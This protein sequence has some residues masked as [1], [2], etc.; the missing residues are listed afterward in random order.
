[1]PPAAP[2]HLQWSCPELAINHEPQIQDTDTL[3]PL[4]KSCPAIVLLAAIALGQ[5]LSQTAANWPMIGGTP[6]NTHYST[7]TQIDRSNVASLQQAW[8]FDTGESGG[9]ETTPTVI[10]GVL[11]TFTPTQKVV[12][13]NAATGK[14]LWTFDSGIKGTGPDRGITWWTDGK[15]PRLLAG[16]MNF[17]Y[18]LD[19]ATG[20]PISS[21]GK[22]GRIDLRENLGREPALQSVALTSPG[23]LYKNLLIVGGRNPETLPA[24][25][26]DI[27]AYSVLTGQLRW[28]FHTIPHPGEFG[29]NTWPK[30]AWQKSGAANNWAGMAVDTQRGIVYVP[31]GSAVPDFYG[32]TRLGNDLFANTLLAL[33]ANTGKRLWHFQGVHHDMWD[34]DFPAAPIL[35][36][37]QRGGQSIPAIA[38]TTKQGYLYLFN[39]TTGAPLFPIE[40]RPYPPST[41]PGEQASPTQP[42]P[43]LPEPFARQALTED[44]LTNR[45][46][47]AHAWALQRF[48]EV[49]HDGQFTPLSVGQ[50]TFVYPS[51]EG[52]A[53][54]GG[55]A[56]DPATGILYVNANNYA[57]LGALAVSSGGSPGRV[58]YLNQCSVCHGDHRQGSAEFPTL[59]GIHKKL[60]LDQITATIHQGKGRMPAMPVEG[61]TLQSLLEYLLTDKD[62]SLAASEEQSPKS[63]AAASAPQPEVA[64]YQNNCAIC[65]G[66]HLEG[67]APVF[68]A[69]LGVGAR[70]SNDQ[71]LA[72]IHNGKG[73]MPGFPDL[74]SS[75]TDALLALLRPPAPAAPESGPR[76]YTMT[77]YR[78]F[79]DPDGYPAT[80][81]PWG[82]LN[83]L[84]LAT[85]KYLWQIPLGQYPELAAQG[86]PDTGSENYGGPVVTAGGLIFIAATN[87]DHKIRALDKTTG[88]LLWQATLPF[89]GNATPAI[90][91]VN[92][93]QFVVIAAGGSSMNPRGPTGGVYIAFSLPQ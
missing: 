7:L 90:Y 46:A 85:G 30:D 92:G 82:T 50:D 59:L 83:A 13:L 54:W 60:T 80:A 65:H 21:F 29:Y 9:L 33:D 41:T 14:L 57:S 42:Y 56:V 53:E 78:R 93:R 32:Q 72:I 84:D 19:P 61:K 58:V 4:S 39:R 48:R 79:N 27:R 52:G 81:T 8:Q 22:N 63:P 89:A 68:P 25:P 38:Q 66:D 1:M 36:S 40:N 28:S 55:P 45:T 71:L 67:V 18:A 86:L 10:D 75:E 2:I 16:V 12:A 47:E 17:V 49:R 37:V 11:Y 74:S 34:R 44:T 35:V 5:A 77:G 23:V 43:T 3:T 15:H 62:S 70:Y 31:T 76:Q 73:K 26:G 88:K 51:F 24:P 20:H 64:A 91:E 69:L 87:F 6:G